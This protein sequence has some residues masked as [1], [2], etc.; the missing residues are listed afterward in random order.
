[1]DL[2]TVAERKAIIDG[3]VDCDA[4]QYFSIAIG[5]SAVEAGQIRKLI[6]KI[7]STWDDAKLM[8]AKIV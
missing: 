3:L 5:D 1:M 7:Y 2:L 8:S 4:K 6:R